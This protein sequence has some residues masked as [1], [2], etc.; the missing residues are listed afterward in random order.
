MGYFGETPTAKQTYGRVLRAD[1]RLPVVSHME[2]EILN[3][4]GFTG[5]FLS[6]NWG[7]MGAYAFAS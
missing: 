2:C 6:A 1:I 5:L 4:G 7:W 3:L